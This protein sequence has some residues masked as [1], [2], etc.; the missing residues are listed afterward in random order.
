[1]KTH[2]SDA[3]LSNKQNHVNTVLIFWEAPSYIQEVFLSLEYS[4]VLTLE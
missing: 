4:F 2:I 3:L 1:M